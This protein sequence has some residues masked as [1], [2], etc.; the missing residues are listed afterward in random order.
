VVGVLRLGK[1]SKCAR[2]GVPRAEPWGAVRGPGDRSIFN[3]SGQV[4]D[5]NAL[6]TAP[7]P[8]RAQLSVR[9]SKLGDVDRT[10]EIILGGHALSTLVRRVRRTADM[11][12][13]ELAA[14]AGVSASMIGQLE[15]GGRA[16]SLPALQRILA[17][18]GYGLVVVDAEGRLVPPLLVWP[19]VADLAGRRFPAHL[20]TIVDPVYGEWWAD[21]Y[22]LTA[23][24]ETFRRSRVYR[25]WQR[26]RSRWEVRVKQLR[27]VPPPREPVQPHRLVERP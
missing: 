18:A 15:I 27:N 26:R 20:D 21:V 14:A 16:P 2:G 25:D 9:P 17:V 8:L 6:S 12:Q 5:N 22:G 23:P 10:D 7:R 13:R 3:R 19:E 1:Q 11:S 24:P 4:V